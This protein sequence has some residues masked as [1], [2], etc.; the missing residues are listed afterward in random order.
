MSL[1]RSALY[2][3][4]GSA[5]TLL[6]VLV[7]LSAPYV[8]LAAR[9]AADR[10]PSQLVNGNDRAELYAE[11]MLAPAEILRSLKSMRQ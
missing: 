6:D 8:I 2:L 9:S 7:L 4:D 1:S 3:H 10:I 5:E 11:A